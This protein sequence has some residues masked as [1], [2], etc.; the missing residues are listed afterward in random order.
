MARPTGLRSRQ[1]AV[2]RVDYRSHRHYGVPE[3]PRPGRIDPRSIAPSLDN[4]S[5]D[6]RLH[7]DRGNQWDF[8]DPNAIPGFGPLDPTDKIADLVAQVSKGLE[9][10]QD[11][12]AEVPPPIDPVRAGPSIRTASPRTNGLGSSIVTR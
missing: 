11:V 4:R 12:L 7:R 5:D 10:V 2:D 3:H 6:S 8:N 1:P 9:Q